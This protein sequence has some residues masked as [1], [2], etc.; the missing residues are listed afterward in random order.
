[1]S[2]QVTRHKATSEQLDCAIRLLKEG[3][4]IA[5]ITLAAAATRVLIDLLGKNA[6]E[7]PSKL[8]RSLYN[9]LPLPAHRQQEFHKW[10]NEVYDWLRHADMLPGATMEISEMEA[11]MWIMLGVASFSRHFNN[12]TIEMKSFSEERLRSNVSRN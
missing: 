12:M 9:Q 10:L 8:F 4:V 1:M 5:A 7:T 11:Q 2:S 6:S 3:H